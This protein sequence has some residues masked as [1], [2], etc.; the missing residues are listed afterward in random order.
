M[1]I[2]L[3]GKHLEHVADKNIKREAQDTRIFLSS[4]KGFNEI[5]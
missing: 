3:F 1:K 2:N 4:V 5:H